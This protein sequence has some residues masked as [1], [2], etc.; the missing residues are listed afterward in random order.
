[1]MLTRSICAGR[2]ALPYKQCM[3]IM[4]EAAEP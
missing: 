4:M 2:E 3:S 1:M